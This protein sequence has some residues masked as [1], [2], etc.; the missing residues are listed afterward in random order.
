MSPA[1]SS[2]PASATTS[3]RFR[4][5]LMPGGGHDPRSRRVWGCPEKNSRRASWTSRRERTLTLPR[6]AARKE[7]DRA[8]GMATSSKR[9]IG[10]AIRRVSES[11]ANGRPNKDQKER[12]RTRLVFSSSSVRFCVSISHPSDLDKTFM[13]KASSGLRAAMGAWC[14][15]RVST[16][17]K[18]GD[19]A[20]RNPSRSRA[21]QLPPSARSTRGRSPMPLL[22]APEPERVCEQ[23][24]VSRVH[25][26]DRVR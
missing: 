3:S 20:R 19:R 7:I 14:R 26:G 4:S 22:P 24:A 17:S 15:G 5:S 1:R 8:I 9:G 6:S 10:S 25:H 13:L 12:N 2:P 21:L 11:L 18:G 23:D 16:L